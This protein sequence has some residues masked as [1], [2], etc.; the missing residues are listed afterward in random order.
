METDPQRILI[1]LAK[2]FA[3][4][5]IEWRVG[6]TSRDKRSGIA[7]AYIDARAVMDRFDEVMGPNWKREYPTIQ[8]TAAGLGGG[9]GRGGDDEQGERKGKGKSASRGLPHLP[10]DRRR[11]DLL[12]GTRKRRDGTPGRL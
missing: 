12:G 4:S 8:R 10:Q 6:S 1:A 11:V 9:G 5:E 2:P 3:P 7:L